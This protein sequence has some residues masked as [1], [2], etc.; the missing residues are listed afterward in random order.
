MLVTAEMVEQMKPGSVVVDLASESGGNVEGSVAGEVVR[1]GNAQVWGGRN[2]P[3]QM[4]GPASKLYAQNVVSL[5]T[6]MTTK[7]DEGNPVFAPDYADEILSGSCV[8]Q[9]G[10][11]VHDATREAI[12]GPASPSAEPA[13]PAKS[14]EPAEPVEATGSVVPDEQLDLPYDQ[15]ADQ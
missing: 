8:T 14:A 5:V 11:I 6:L 12:E 15:E 4:P 2:V 10:R 9:D 7:D 3:S 1:I 13:A